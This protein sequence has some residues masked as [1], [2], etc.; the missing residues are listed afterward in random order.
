MMLRS[1]ATIVSGGPVMSSALT[2]LVLPHALRVCRTSL[3]LA[4]SW[5]HLV[6][7]AVQKYRRLSG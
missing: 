5:P 1:V 2:L 3:R 6:K 4:L 7:L